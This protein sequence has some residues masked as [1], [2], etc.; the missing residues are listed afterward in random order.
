MYIN[1]K[2]ITLIAV[3]VLAI[4]AIA[5]AVNYWP[6][7]Q[8][9]N[10]RPVVVTTIP[11]LKMIAE[12]VVGDTAEVVALVQPGAS[13]HTFEVTPA[14]IKEVQS[15]RILF[16]IG[17]GL[18]EWVS[19]IYRSAGSI[20]VYNLDSSVEL[21]SFGEDGD[22]ESE[23]DH[24]EEEHHEE[25]GHHD[26]EEEDGHHHDHEGSDPHYWLDP[27]QARRIATVMTEELS[28]LYPEHA[29]LYEENNEQFSASLTT[30]DAEIRS[31][32]DPLTKRELITFH[33]S[34]AYFAEAY[35][36]E[37]V[38]VFETAPG[39][40]PTARY[41]QELMHT[42]QEHDVQSVFSEPQ[43]STAVLTPFIED[44]GLSVYE[45]D[46]LGGIE[47]RDSYGEFLLYNAR[48]IAEALK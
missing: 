14:T 27:A 8:P 18:D 10:D 29:S 16:A 4:A 6:S 39:K 28:Q 2:K 11:P 19:D 34:W 26:D 12:E 31:I 32:L 9:A 3:G 5:F 45:M 43:L 15:S 17:S 37:I 30:L 44:L 20:T 25:E 33:D 41:L 23:E 22:H 35:G 40:E 38:G 42:A 46:P 1:M 7:G 47:G 36:L 21:R 48:T 24:H 13:P